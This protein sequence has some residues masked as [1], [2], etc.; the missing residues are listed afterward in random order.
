[1]YTLLNPL[2][3]RHLRACARKGTRTSERKAHTTNGE[4]VHD[5]THRGARTHAYA[6]G[7]GTEQ[8]RPTKPTAGMK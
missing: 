3:E 4:Q 5:Q 2:P 1:M 7:S 8:P 6:A